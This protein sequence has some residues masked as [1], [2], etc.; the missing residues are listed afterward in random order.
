MRA[1]TTTVLRLLALVGKELVEV[2][3]RPVRSSVSS[4]GRS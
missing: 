1:L 3:R 2:I 4:S